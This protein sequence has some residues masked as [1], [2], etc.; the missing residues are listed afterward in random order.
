M[1]NVKVTELQRLASLAADLTAL[2]D[3][4]PLPDHL[5]EMMNLL[6]LNVREEVLCMEPTCV[7]DVSAKL[8]MVATMNVDDGAFDATVFSAI[9]V[10]QRD[11]ASI[12]GAHFERSSA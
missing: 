12:Y 4:A 3:Q 10:C 2:F 11:A 7:R 1:T 8:S 9:R 6:I 5:A